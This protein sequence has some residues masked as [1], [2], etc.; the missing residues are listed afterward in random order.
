MV[1]KK[2]DTASKN[3]LLDYLYGLE[4]FGIKLG[5]D[6]MHQLM[7]L[8]DHPEKKFKS[9]HIT[10]TNGKG[11][12]AA[13]L[14]SIL[15]RAGYSVGL[16]T[17]PHLVEF[18]ERVQVKGKC[19]LNEELVLLVDEIKDKIA[20]QGN[21]IQPT[22]FEFTTALAFLYF[23]RKKVEYAIIEVGMGGRFDA[24]NVIIPE[25]SVITHVDFDH[26]KYLGETKEKIAYEKAGIIKQRGVVVTGETDESILVL[27]STICIERSAELHVLDGELNVKNIFSDAVGR[28][29]IVCGINLTGQRFSLKGVIEGEFDILMLGEHQVRNAALAVFAA[30][31]LGIDAATIRSGVAKAVWRGRL[32]VLSKNPLVLLDGAH[33]MDGVLALR[34]FIERIDGKKVFVLGFSK[35]KDIENMLSVLVPFASRIIFTQGNFKPA[36]LEYLEKIG[37]KLTSVPIE[38]STVANALRAAGSYASNG[39]VIIIA[40]SLYLAGDVLACVENEKFFF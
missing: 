32:Q 9:V 12:T 27:F 35:D 20:L 29:E 4:R 23:A 14:Y 5:L 8:L 13:F 6:V 3:A 15:Q 21:K 37:R 19:I 24:T 38:C 36:D 28:E 26:M 11:S 7:D 31:Y 34:R 25:I 2:D 33:N 22:F 10:G 18:N 39:E 17:S 30:Y 16:Y 40:G 1:L